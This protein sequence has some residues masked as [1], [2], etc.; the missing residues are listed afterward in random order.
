MRAVGQESLYVGLVTSGEEVIDLY[1]LQWHKH[2]GV[3]RR[4]RG[5]TPERALFVVE[6]AEGL[7]AVGNAW[8]FCRA[9]E[10]MS[11]TELS[12][13]VERSRAVALE[14]ERL[15]NHAAAI[16]A[17]CQATGLSVAQAQAEIAL[18]QL[19]RL[20][21]AVF[22]HRYLFGVIAVGGV[23]RAPDTEA[24]EKLLPSAYDELRSVIQSL[25]STNSFMDR[26]EACGIVTSEEATRLG[27]VGPVARGSGIDLDTRR[28][29]SFGAYRD[30]NFQVAGRET[31]DVMGRMGVMA[32]E[33]EESARLVNEF[34]SEGV[35]SGVVDVTNTGGSALGWSESP[36]GESLAWLELDRE[37]RV[38]RARLRPGSVRNWRAFDDA[39]RSRNVFTDIPIIEA[40]FWLTVAGF[41]R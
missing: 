29:H 19:L 28:D 5:L 3:E 30:M 2:R 14:L 11:G 20:N 25:C 15:Y 24:I 27:L 33:A 1:L 31:G 6:R 16:A 41:A 9:I 18:E 36:R 38:Q 21:L 40:S 37:G 12:A 4:L 13:Q 10:E 7:S 22:E 17:L 8:A 23:S 26:L 39:A 35:G 32:S 34:A